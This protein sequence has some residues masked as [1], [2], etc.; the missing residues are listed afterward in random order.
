MNIKN[1]VKSGVA[2][3][4]ARSVL[5]FL[6]AVTTAA[7]IGC[8]FSQIK[9]DPVVDPGFISDPTAACDPAVGA[10][11]SKPLEIGMRLSKYVADNRLLCESGAA[12]ILVSRDT[13]PELRVNADGV[14]MAEGDDVIEK[15]ALQCPGK[16]VVV[17]VNVRREGT[18]C[19]PVP[20][21]L[22][23]AD[24]LKLNIAA[25][26]ELMTGNYKK[27]LELAKKAVELSRP[28]DILLH[29]LGTAWM[30]VGNFQ[31]AEKALADALKCN[32]D[33]VIIR[34]A[35]AIALSELGNKNAYGE[36]IE[37]LFAD[38]PESDPLHWDLMCRSADNQ[39]R[40]GN[41][42]KAVKLAGVACDHGIPVCCDLGGRT[43]KFPE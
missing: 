25:V 4:A 14:K 29:T 3:Q 23:P 24:A 11:S 31:N 1:L 36:E 37:R 41:M 26:Q 42:G 43:V 12:A 28:A 40:L 27:G 13:M 33:S 8:N 22:M 35:H 19:I 32:P 38:V 2:G 17:Y 10:K 7:T 30:T 9:D 18:N 34:L 21:S 6:A 20:F 39:K 5:L 16:E 15:F